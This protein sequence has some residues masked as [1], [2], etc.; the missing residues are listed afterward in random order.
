M[1]P[2]NRTVLPKLAYDS[3]ASHLQAPTLEEGFADITVVDF[4]VSHSASFP[5]CIQVATV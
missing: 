3:F 1:N 5:R 2:E 4:L